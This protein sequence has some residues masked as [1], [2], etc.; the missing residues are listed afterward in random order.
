M[1]KVTLKNPVSTFHKSS[2]PPG[3]WTCSSLKME[4]VCVN[5]VGSSALLRP[6]YRWR[7]ADRLYITHSSDSDGLSPLFLCVCVCVSRQYY[8]TVPQ[9][10]IDQTGLSAAQT[11]VDYVVT[12]IMFKS[13]QSLFFFFLRSLWQKAG[14]RANWISSVDLH[15]HLLLSDSDGL[16]L[17]DVK[18]KIILVYFILQLFCSSCLKQIN[19]FMTS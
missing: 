8:R 12:W 9:S 2:S 5:G 15:L 19:I 11:E 16:A 18:L 14:C 7:T 13:A 17:Q 6:L 10:Q 3:N 1:S 4:C